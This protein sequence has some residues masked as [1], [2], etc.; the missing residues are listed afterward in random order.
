MASS[1]YAEIDVGW[2]VI[3]CSDNRSATDRTNLPALFLP[4]DYAA[5]G[6]GA[7]IGYGPISSMA[8]SLLKGFSDCSSVLLGRGNGATMESVER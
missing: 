4:D 5:A 7:L 1:A 6:N 8:M 2:L 3:G